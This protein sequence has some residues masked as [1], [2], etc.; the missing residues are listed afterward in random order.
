MDQIYLIFLFPVLRVDEFIMN[1]KDP[2]SSKKEIKKITLKKLHLHI[3]VNG[4]IG[5]GMLVRWF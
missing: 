1:Q 4:S 2:Q 3:P 5:R